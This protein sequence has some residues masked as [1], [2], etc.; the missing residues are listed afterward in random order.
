[1]T[2]VE[3]DRMPRPP[4]PPRPPFDTVAFVLGA[5]FML[6]A[7]LGLIGTPLVRRLDL[8]L[9]VP[10]ALVAIGL[11]LLAGSLAPA[12]RRRATPPDAPPLES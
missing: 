3:E 7:A 4:R 11:A 10:V 6:V 9:V 1:M 5:L 2:A 12:R 8:G